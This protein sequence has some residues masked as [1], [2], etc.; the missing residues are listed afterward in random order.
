MIGFEL[1]AW[2]E[3]RVFLGNWPGQ[4]VGKVFLLAPSDWVFYGGGIVA[5]GQTKKEAA[6]RGVYLLKYKKEE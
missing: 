2:Q 5:H 4:S 6:E 1:V 3:Y